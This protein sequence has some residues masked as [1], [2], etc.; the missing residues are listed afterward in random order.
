MLLALGRVGV[1]VVMAAA[2]GV[3]RSERQRRER[4]AQHAALMHSVAGVQLYPR[5]VAPHLEPPPRARVAR[6]RA[7]V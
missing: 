1:T 3:A 5:L 6:P 2:E 7:Q 4:E